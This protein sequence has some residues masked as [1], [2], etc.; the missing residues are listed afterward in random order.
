MQEDSGVTSERTGGVPRG[1]LKRLSDR[2]ILD[3][4][5]QRFGADKALAARL[6]VT[7]NLVHSWRSRGLSRDGRLRLE[8]ALAA[9]VAPPEPVQPEPQVVA[10]L[11]EVV[12]TLRAIQSDL[13][14]LRASIDDVKA[15]QAEGAKRLQQL[16]ARVVLSEE[17]VKLQFARMR[18]DRPLTR[19]PD[20]DG[21]G[22]P[23]QL[24]GSASEMV[25]RAARDLV[26]QYVAAAM[27]G[28]GPGA[29]EEEPR[30]AAAKRRKAARDV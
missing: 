29:A 7:K 8:H 4:A 13:V 19:H 10:A 24:S 2:E 12:E 25:R 20:D 23:L 11:R 1:D 6:G 16:E 17:A 18:G 5:T 22:V 28:G 30:R 21:I 15:A 27:S 26:D 3:L 9:D 14:A